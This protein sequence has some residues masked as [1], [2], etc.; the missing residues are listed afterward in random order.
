MK[1]V[2]NNKFEIDDYA[3]CIKNSNQLITVDK[4]YKILW[5]YK[6]SGYLNIICDNNLIMPL[7]DSYFINKKNLKDLR[8]FKL[9]K[10]NKYVQNK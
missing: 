4:E 10:L 8:K 2:K 3:I 6:N 1:L 9:E 7:P 5:I